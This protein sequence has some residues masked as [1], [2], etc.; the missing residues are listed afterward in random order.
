MMK[1]SFKVI[2]FFQDPGFLKK[3]GK[4]LSAYSK[5]T[6]LIVANPEFFFSTLNLCSQHKICIIDEPA[7]LGHYS[8]F[9]RN[10]LSNLIIFIYRNDNELENVGDH[11]RVIDYYLPYD[12]SEVLLKQ[13]LRSSEKGLSSASVNQNRQMPFKLYNQ[14]QFLTFQ[15]NS[16][17]SRIFITDKEHAILGYND[18]F[19]SDVSESGFDCLL[20]KKLSSIVEKETFITLSLDNEQLSLT[21]EVSYFEKLL[22]HFEPN[23]TYHVNLSKYR[24]NLFSDN[25]FLILYKYDIIDASDEKEDP[26]SDRRLLEILMDNI[27]DTI[28]F[29]DIN[30]KFVRLNRAQARLV[31]VENPEDAYGKTD[32]D[33]FNIEHSKKAFSDEQKIIFEAKP[34][35]SLEYIGTKDGRYRWMYSSKVPVFGE[36]GE[37]IGTVGITRDVD[38]MMRAEHKLKAERDLLQ[39]LIDHIPSPIYFKDLESKFT[40][41]NLAQAKLLGVSSTEDVVGKSDFDYYPDICASEYYSDE[42]RLI[43]TR[44]PVFNKTEKVIL[45]N[46][47]LKWFSTTKIA[48]H[49]E[50]GDLS[51]ILGV[52]HDITEQILVKQKLEIAKEK[53]EVAS[54][55]KSNFLSNMSHEI[56]TPMNGVIGM[57]EVLNMTDLDQEQKKI[58][59][60]IIRSG[61]NLL[62]IINDILD[63]SKI[64]NGKLEIE[65]LHI[66]IK[67]IVKEVFEMMAFSAREKQIV[68][69]NKIDQNIPEFVLGDSLRLKQILINLISNAIKFTKEGE[70]KVE[71]IFLGNTD[72]AHCIMFKVTDTG[73]GID[74][75]VKQYLFDAF[76]Q[77]DASTSRK[78]GGT[79]LGLAISSKLV[80]MMGGKLDVMSEIGKGSTFF[81]D[82]CFNRVIIDESDMI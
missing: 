27:N 82:I 42:R 54:T 20:G 72:L 41:V 39:L 45:Q 15:G 2:Q 59:S 75:T 60:L 8:F 33:F 74:P 44:V 67:Y 3:F 49:D 63:F 11:Y 24:Y 7:L 51:G 53:A 73:I 69:E 34:I 31:G 65:M 38:K 43:E 22:M 70:V 4:C 1:D 14:K 79:G 19:F 62:N 10:Y 58:V 17:N 80:S 52:S 37:V 40:R 81:F 61:N 26:F 36:K 32:F 78:Y 21:G 47:D 55:A 9:E 50:E 16:S 76:T 23:L 77:A 56:R 48:I 5:K 6:D 12:F 57:A 29:K 64:E 13:I 68:F 66:D 71:A 46:N 30:S 25:D 28:Y 35:K 18:S